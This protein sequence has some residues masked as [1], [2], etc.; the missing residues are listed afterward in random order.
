MAADM[1]A[2]LDVALEDVRVPA[3]INDAN[4]IIR[5]QN[6]RS[7]ARFGDSVG[8]PVDAI[9]APESRAEARTQRLRKV[10]GATKVSDYEAVMR[11]ASGAEARV[12]LHT[13]ALANGGRV[14]GVFGLAEEVG[15]AK[16]RSL[17][18]NP[19]TP[20]Q[21]EVLY[22]LAHGMSTAQIADDLHLAPETV[23]NYIRALLR[24]MHVHSRLEAVVE[25]RRRGLVD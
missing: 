14:V 3:W 21:H 25:A 6:A 7:R 18:D 20:R 11:L 15:A 19:L 9:V 17:P 1:G 12:E 2:D 8:K 22:K 5:W 4:G 13:V 16:K 23:R 24:R 10:L